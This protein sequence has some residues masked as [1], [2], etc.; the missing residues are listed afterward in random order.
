MQVSLTPWFDRLGI[1]F[2]STACKYPL[3]VAVGKPID[4]EKTPGEPTEA[5][6][7]KLHTKFC[8]ALRELFDRHKHDPIFD[9]VGGWSEKQLYFENEIPGTEMPRKQA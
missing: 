7:D 1:P 4:V 5:Q 2:S 9:S 8:G 6:V 3:L